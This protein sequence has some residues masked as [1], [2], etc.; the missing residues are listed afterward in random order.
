M[1]REAP[2]PTLAQTRP[3]KR[4]RPEVFYELTRSMCPVCRA[5]IDAQILLRYNKVYMRKRCKEHGLFEA[6]VYGDAQMYTS[7]L[8]FNRAL[9]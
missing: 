9:C 2:T 1:D 6:L 4:D 8:K 5:I 3:V 7:S